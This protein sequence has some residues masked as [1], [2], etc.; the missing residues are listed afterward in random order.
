MD[1]DAFHQT[2]EDI[3]AEVP[4]ELLRELNGGIFVLPEV[5]IHPKAVD[6]NIYA[7]GEYHVELPGLGRYIV[8]YYGSFER[9]Y[10]AGTPNGSP[11]LRAD[12]RKTLLHE[13]RHHVES[14][15]GT[16]D[17]EIEDEVNIAKFNAGKK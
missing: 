9:V 7:M 13:I 15:S 6:G 4:E 12:I 2:L 8:L 11:R 1:I 17:L 16:R 3:A 14:L 5:K 10:G